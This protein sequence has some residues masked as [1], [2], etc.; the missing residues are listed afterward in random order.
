MC[1][2]HYSCVPLIDPGT[3]MDEPRIGRCVNNGE[4]FGHAC[5]PDDIVHSPCAT[6]TF[7]MPTDHCDTPVYGKF[8]EVDDTQDGVC[9]LPRREGNTCD[10]SWGEADKC[11]V[12][13]PG[14]ECVSGRCR[15]SCTTDDDCPCDTAS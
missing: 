3:G 15:R 13:E 4:S 8:A 14:L 9:L 2:E 11:E 6:G 7:C 1:P 10:G 12:C 5:D